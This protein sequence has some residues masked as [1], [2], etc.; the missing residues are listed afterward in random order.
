MAK[1]ST[2]NIYEKI[3]SRLKLCWKNSHSLSLDVSI[4]RGIH[5]IS[6][7]HLLV[8]LSL[9][10]EH[11]LICSLT[12]LS[13]S[14]VYS[15]I[16]SKELFIR[17]LYFK[18]PLEE[19]RE[20]F[21][22]LNVKQSIKNLLWSMVRTDNAD[23]DS[24]HTHEIIIDPLEYEKDFDQFLLKKYNLQRIATLLEFMLV[25]EYSERSERLRGDDLSIDSNE[26]SVS[27]AMINQSDHEQFERNEIYAYVANEPFE[28]IF[29]LDRSRSVPLKQ[30]ESSKPVLNTALRHS[31]YLP[32]KSIVKRNQELGT[33]KPITTN[34]KQ[35]PAVQMAS[36]LNA[37]AV[38]KSQQLALEILSQQLFNKKLDDHIA[39]LSHTELNDAIHTAV[40][41]ATNH[42]LDTIHKKTVERVTEAES[43][44]ITENKTLIIASGHGDGR[45]SIEIPADA[46]T[47]EQREILGQ[48]CDCIH[49]RLA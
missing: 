43:S 25:P 40:H 42:I 7:S 41:S 5:R 24:S 4:Y 29:P 49:H 19:I 8:T 45:G 15:S 28:M 48:W 46:L 27:I 18:P 32:P 12:N 9:H 37:L 13:S 1:K 11:S 23:E 3:F 30:S 38:K 21:G 31:T 26:S 22:N 16:L 10:D 44:D 33:L 20:K 6:G 39:K 17:L 2:K 36:E 35:E 14:N 47:H 34:T